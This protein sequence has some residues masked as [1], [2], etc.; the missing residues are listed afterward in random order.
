M[1]A[2]LIFTIAILIAF[3][4]ISQENV[5]DKINF[6]SPEATSAMIYGNQKVNL[7]SGKAEI[8]IP[9]YKAKNNGIEVNIELN[10]NSNGLRPDEHPGWVGNGWSLSCGGLITREVVG[11]EDELKLF[12]DNAP[13][14]AEDGN[15][16]LGYLYN[17]NDLKSNHWSQANN[18]QALHASS[19]IFPMKDYEPDLFHCSFP[20]F[21]GTFL[22]SEQGKW[23]MKEH[24]GIIIEESLNPNGLTDTV[25]LRTTTWPGGYGTPPAITY[26]TKFKH[27]FFEGFKITDI[28]GKIYYFGKY[29]NEAGSMEA[30]EWSYDA[31]TIY[32]WGSRMDTWHLVKIVDPLTN[33]EMEFEYEKKDSI[34]NVAKFMSISIDSLGGSYNNYQFGDLQSSVS[35][36]AATYRGRIVEPAYLKSII[37]N[38]KSIHF[39]TSR[40]TELSA[41]FNSLRL[42]RN[43][44]AYDAYIDDII[45]GYE[46]RLFGADRTWNNQSTFN[47]HKLDSITMSNHNTPIKKFHF[48]Y[49]S[50]PNLRLNLLSFRTDDLNPFM[51]DYNFSNSLP[52]YHQ[53]ATDHWGYH[54]GML[55]PF[56]NYYDQAL[57]ISSHPTPP[58]FSE[59]RNYWQHRE[60]NV[61]KMDAEI[62]TKITYPTLGSTSFTYEPLYYDKHV[63]RDSITG[64]ISVRTNNGSANTPHSLGY[65]GGLRVKKTIDDPVNGNKVIKEYQYY[66]GILSGE[67]KYFWEN[68]QPTDALSVQVKYNA[69]M[70]HSFVPASKGLNHV[71]YSKVEEVLPGNGK[72]TYHFNNFDSHPDDNFITTLYEEQSSH[73]PLID[74][75]YIRGLQNK[76]EVFDESGR[77]L[78]EE[79]RTFS[80]HYKS[81]Y[82]PVRA[83]KLE[84]LQIPEAA[85]WF[86]PYTAYEIPVFPFYND[87]NIRTQYF[88][89]ANHPV[90]TYTSKEKVVKDANGNTWWKKSLDHEG[91]G[92]VEYTKYYIQIDDS[93]NISGEAKA[94]RKLRAL[95]VKNIPLETFQCIDGATLA[96]WKMT[97]GK[98]YEYKLFN[99]IPR[100]HKVWNT[101]TNN[102]VN[103]AGNE[104]RYENGAIIKSPL[105]THQGLVK[106]SETISNYTPNG[107]ISEYTQT[108]NQKM[109]IYWDDQNT[110]PVAKVFPASNL[111][112]FVD[113][114]HYLPGS[115]TNTTLSNSITGGG[116]GRSGAAN[117]T[118]DHIR[119]ALISG[120][121]FIEYLQSKGK[122]L[123]KLNGHVV[124]SSMTNDYHDLKRLRISVQSTPSYLE[125]S[126]DG[127]FTIIDNLLIYPEHCRAEVYSYNQLTDK[128]IKLTNTEGENKTF[129]YD[130]Y[131][132]LIWEKSK[133]DLVKTYEYHD[134]PQIGDN[135]IVTNTIRKPNIGLSDIPTLDHHSIKSE[136]LIVDGLGR[137]LQKI[138]INSSPAGR[139][140]I[141]LFDYNIMGEAIKEY[142]PFTKN[143]PSH[144][145]VQNA[146]QFQRSFYFSPVPVVNEVVLDSSPLQRPVLKGAPGSAWEIGSGNEVKTL[147]RLN[148]ANEVFE[149]SN[150]GFDGYYYPENELFVEITIDENGNQSK[151]Y[152]DIFGKEI[153]RDQE[154]SKTY[155]VFDAFCRLTQIL[156]P[157]TSALIGTQNFWSPD[158]Q[159]GTF[160]YTYDSRSRVIRKDIPGKETEFLYYDKLDRPV[161]KI[162][163]NGN[164]HFQKFDMYGRLIID[165]LYFG[166]SIP[167]SNQLAFELEAPGNQFG[168]TETNSFPISNFEAHNVYFY[169]HY[170]LDRDGS[171][172]PSES[173]ISDPAGIYNPVIDSNPVGRETSTLNLLL[174]GNGDYIRTI[175]YFDENGNPVFQRSENELEGENITYTEYTFTNMPIKSETSQRVILDN[176]GI[177]TVINKRFT[178]DHRDRLINTYHQVNNGDWV[179]ISKQR[180]NERDLLL[181]KKIGLSNT[182][183]LQD[184]DYAYN[185]RGWLTNI[186][187]FQSK[188]PTSVIPNVISSEIG[189]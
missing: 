69:F 152:K 4:A 182:G 133:G 22:R 116:I 12:I 137:S 44:S 27:G 108:N 185:I 179:H 146:E 19:A 173:F 127:S 29:L 57:D 143:N 113:F 26:S 119:T 154:G 109:Y 17:S 88:Y 98:Y 10:Y 67:Q 115:N 159:K 180:Y 7:A 123:I 105:Y 63:Y 168:Y 103:L 169:D 35:D 183:Y 124:D 56:Q 184:I 156:P 74:R 6:P 31:M 150:V 84:R 134:G 94:L 36:I 79:N 53:T 131:E 13:E 161:L 81:V 138:D 164:K 178:Y 92:Y 37:Y 93:V 106:P 43:A 149:H 114:D 70:T 25:I 8:S 41:D 155:N 64:A 60:P 122:V 75:S 145:L 136:K 50:N 153:M 15:Y 117:I 33:A 176:V 54:N 107:N 144:G 61:A 181:E 47:W 51:F 83:V 49:T 167:T 163:G 170:D 9:V 20:G 128:A 97:N 58:S 177:S 11:Q 73:Q 187:K 99:G 101:E 34:M 76:K 186:N 87:S 112:V 28:D 160:R 62:L 39:H 21:S 165:G 45:Y 111:T 32:N 68:F 52:P 78:L 16:N 89:P 71:V 189:Q 23:I 140:V 55:D 151:T 141:Q 126:G 24:P 30:C 121:Y 95:N 96:D 188:N 14:R 77:L 132:R 1:R 5:I 40:S 38:S 104:M 66:D 85:V 175:N 135:F 158:V 171:V 110:R 174:N 157:K 42:N 59:L 91:K 86:T 82:K 18:L 72:T 148:F 46:L 80:T 118:N 166:N 162:D 100:L 2:I 130:N 125:I 142:L 120:D 48:E 90:Q 3:T 102:P 129:G 147:Y 139:D 65:A 172:N